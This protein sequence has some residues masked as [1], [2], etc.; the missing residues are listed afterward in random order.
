MV[1]RIDFEAHH[2]FPELMQYFSTRTEYPIYDPESISLHRSPDFTL[3]DPYRLIR[4][5][6]SFEERIKTMDEHGVKMQVLSV[7]CGIDYLTPEES[8]TW[9]QKANDFV[10]SGMK[11]YPGRF[12]GFAALPI[13]DLDASVK[14]LERCMKEL[15]FLGWLV[16]SNF[17]NSYIDDDQ[18]FPLLEKLAEYGGILYIHPTTPIIDRLKG[19]GSQLAAAPFGFGIDVSIALMRMICKGV[20]DK[21]PNLKVMIGHLGEVFPYTMRRMNDKIRGYHSVAPAVNQKLPEYYFKHN[22][23]ITTSGHFCPHAMRCAID[24]MGLDRILFATDYPYERPEHVDQFFD[25][26]PIN[27]NDLNQIFFGNAEKLIGGGV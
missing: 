27:T 21:L 1:N 8:I 22:I 17:G 26:L 2:Y 25:S 20:F 14:E 12:Q 6:E 3:K 11:A 19:L 10:Y 9:S 13:A 18:H 7:S 5:Q 16:D 15:G 24:V 4:L 23:W